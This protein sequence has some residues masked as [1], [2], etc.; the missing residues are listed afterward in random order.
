[1]IHQDSTFV[2]LEGVTRSYGEGATHAR[3]LG[4]IDLEIRTGELTLVMGPS[5]S[6]KT[7][8]LSILGLLLAPTEGRMWLA[9]VE[10]SG[11]PESRCAELRRRH[12]AFVFQQ[13]H[14]IESLTAAENVR[15]A[16]DLARDSTPGRAEAILERLGMAG[17]ARSLPRNLS[18]GQKQRVGIAR[19]LAMPGRLVLADE[20]TAALDSTSG[21]SVMAALA[22]LAEDEGRAVVAVTHDKRWAGLAHR[23][24]EIQDGL[25]SREEVRTDALAIDCS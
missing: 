17:K 15:V 23:T 13:F 12:V 6:G 2:R 5:G 9:G 11:L 21:E 25:V 10:S 16:L 24:I 3:V 18:G 14:L 7:T 19:A 1:M 20:P 8:L 4:P 22:R